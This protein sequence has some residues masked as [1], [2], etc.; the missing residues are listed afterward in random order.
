M[1]VSEICADIVSEIHDHTMPT[2]TYH[3]P[4]VMCQATQKS[5]NQNSKLPL[6][7][8]TKLSW[9]SPA[10]RFEFVSRGARDCAKPF[11]PATLLRLHPPQV[12]EVPPSLQ[13]SLDNGHRL[14]FTLTPVQQFGH[15]SRIRKHVTCVHKICDCLKPSSVVALFSRAGEHR[16]RSCQGT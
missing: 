3:E 4:D 7:I 5:N 1:L 14:T 11:D 13:H 15:C 10:L 16:R 2:N 8:V 9:W 12:S 6:Q